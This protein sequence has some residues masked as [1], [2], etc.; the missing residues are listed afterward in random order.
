MFK[1]L[2]YILMIFFLYTNIQIL[3]IK[4][5]SHFMKSKELKKNIGYKPY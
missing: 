4:K 1:I 2:F 5:N 3:I